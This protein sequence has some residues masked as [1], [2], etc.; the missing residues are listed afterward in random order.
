MRLLVVYIA[1]ATT[2]LF[3]GAASSAL[4]EEHLLAAITNE[5]EKWMKFE[6]PR[7]LEERLS[8]IALPNPLRLSEVESFIDERANVMCSVCKSLVKVIMGYRRNGMDEKKIK[9]VVIELCTK[10][11][12]QTEAVCRGIIELNVPIIMYVIDNRPD[13]AAE[14]FCGVALQKN[15]CSL[16]DEQFEWTIDVD[17]ESLQYIK[18]NKSD[19]TIKIVQISDFHYDPKYEP[20]GNA[21][22]RE[23]TCCR[24]GQNTTN[25]SGKVA[26]YWGDYN[27][28]DVPWHAIVNIIDQIKEHEQDISYIYYTGDIIDHGVWETTRATNI[29]SIS[30]SYHK[31][32]ETFGSVPIYPVLGNHEPN[33]MNEFAPPDVTQDNLS[34]SWLYKML[35]NLWI[36]F[37]WLPES[38][39]STILQGGFYTVSPKKGFR[40]IAINNNLCYIYNWWVLY[41]PKDPSGQLKW[42]VETLLKAES[43]G[44]YVHILTHMPPGDHSCQF[45]W[46][47]E[48]RKIMNRFAHIVVAEFNGHTHNDEFRVIYDLKNTTEAIRVAWNG[49][50]ATT[51]SNVNPNY[52]VYTVNADTYQVEDA[53]TWIYNLTLAN[54]TPDKNPVWFKSYSF[55]EEYELDDLSPTSMND[56]VHRMARNNSILNTYYANYVKQGDPSLESG[57]SESCLATQLCD[58]VTSAV[59]DSTQCD[60]FTNLN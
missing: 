13:L 42:L 22:C 3:E 23:P 45:T 47:R 35:A 52:R 33:P 44:E 19:E 17:D 31:L 43:D 39:R 20:Y 54:E 15:S 48:Y 30:K 57:C 34:T 26:G 28:C 51:Y 2:L 38:T 59:H 24:K 53:D 46:S 36:R 55:K 1:I 50:S 21:D 6:E 25:T 27:D 37:G 12:L 41:E 7:T 40:I 14:S 58:I 4:T 18:T 11:N 49:G 29:E 8:E 32:Y 9:N 16:E 56:L 5:M 10:L 60:Y